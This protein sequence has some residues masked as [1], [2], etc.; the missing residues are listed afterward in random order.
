MYF[1][2]GYKIKFIRLYAVLSANYFDSI[3]ADQKVLPISKILKVEIRN[4]VYH[5]LNRTEILVQ[6]LKLIPTR[7]FY[8][9][10]CVTE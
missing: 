4:N 7:F 2:K 3:Y 9:K 8:L 5:F 10:V 6:K 1:T